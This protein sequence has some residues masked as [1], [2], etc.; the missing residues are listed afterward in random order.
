MRPIA[1]ETTGWHESGHCA[2]ALALGEVSIT[3]VSL[4]PG[5]VRF[6]APIEDPLLDLAVRLGGHVAEQLAFPDEDFD[7]SDDIYADDRARSDLAAYAITGD[8]AT[9]A[10]K[11][12]EV[13]LFVAGLLIEHWNAVEAITLALLQS[14][15]LSGADL[16]PLRC[17]PL[18][19]GSVTG[20]APRA[21]GVSPF[22]L[23]PWARGGEA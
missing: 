7:F 13:R 3:K 14:G 22:G 2:V 18:S 16:D 19:V 15:T 6:V 23:R 21:E 10:A 4:R 17:R 5:R 9:M 1:T 12:A 11:V 8:I 20:D